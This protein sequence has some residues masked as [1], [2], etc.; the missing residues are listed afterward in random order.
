MNETLNNRLEVGEKI[1][2][3]DGYTQFAIETVESIN[4][5][6]KSALLSNNAYISRYP[7]PDGTFNRLN[8]NDGHLPHQS[9]LLIKRATPDM[10]KIRTAVLSLQ[11]IKA[12]IYQLNQ[13]ILKTT[14]PQNWRR[15]S[16][17]KQDRLICLAGH[18][19][20]GIE[21][22]DLEEEDKE[23]LAKAIGEPREQVIPKKR[24]RK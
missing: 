11:K 20:K 19:A 16:E 23:A 24:K 15:W 5:A 6:D 21:E 12:Y 2:Y 10:I 18:I 9:D 22:A 4:K 3:Y 13:G 7:N 1:F 17:T 14:N 8:P